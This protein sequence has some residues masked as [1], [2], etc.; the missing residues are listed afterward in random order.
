MARLA[1]DGN[2]HLV[3]VFGNV[4]ADQMRPEAKSRLRHLNE[5]NFDSLADLG[6]ALALWRYDYN[7]VGPHLSLGHKIPTEA[8]GS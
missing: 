7:N 1:R 4:D 2:Q 5:E 3:P 8:P 6:R